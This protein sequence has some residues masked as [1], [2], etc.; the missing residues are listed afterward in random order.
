MAVEQRR[1]AT[2]TGV[3][4]LPGARLAYE[5]TGAGPPVLK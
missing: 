3:L 4:A 1:R 2:T 5:V